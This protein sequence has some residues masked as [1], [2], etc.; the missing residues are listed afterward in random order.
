MGR[1]R[2][3]SAP[4]RR[5]AG[6]PR[7]APCSGCGTRRRP[8]AAAPAHRPVDSAASFSS[9]SRAPAA[10]IWPAPLRLAGVSPAASMPAA[11]SSGSP[12][13][14]ADMPVGVSAQAAAISAPRRAA[15]AT[16]SAGVRAPETAAA[17]SSPTLCPATTRSV[18]PSR[19][20]R[21][22][23]IAP[24]ATISGW[25]TAVSLIS[26]ASAVVPSRTRSRP[27]SSLHEPSC[28]ATPGSSS[29]AASMP[30]V[31]EPCP[32]AKMAITPTTLSRRSGQR[33]ARHG[34][35]CG[36]AV[37]GMPTKPRWA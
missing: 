36:A 3:G 21:P 15:N 20:S 24:S 23:T 5:R 18:S 28:S 29:Q 4:R 9:A 13:S 31:C 35:R 22:A 12:P 25:V 26:S 6:L 30:G 16:A 19:P 27:A 7:P 11:T 2:R 33:R 14:T 37:V 32:G 1:G 10:T 34:Q 8:A 17:V